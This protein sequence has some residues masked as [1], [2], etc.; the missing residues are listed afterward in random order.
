MRKAGHLVQLY[1][2]RWKPH[3]TE[4]WASS[5]HV[6]NKRIFLCLLT[7]LWCL[8]QLPSDSNRTGALP[9]PPPPSGQSSCL[10]QR[11]SVWTETWSWGCS[12]AVQSQV[13]GQWCFSAL[14]FKHGMLL[15]EEQKVKLTVWYEHICWHHWG[16][17][18]SQHAFPG[19]SP[20]AHL[21]FT[22]WRPYGL[23]ASLWTRQWRMEMPL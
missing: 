9:P 6:W 10:L 21:C 22:Q 19:L 17:L 2:S 15:Q 18:L 3:C 1:L 14:G 13:G 4:Q 11:K 12:L 5:M 8:N 16:S 20:R 23:C 7:I